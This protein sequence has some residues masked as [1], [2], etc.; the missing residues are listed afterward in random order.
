MPALFDASTDTSTGGLSCD[1]NVDNGVPC[2]CTF[3]YSMVVSSIEIVVFMVAVAAFLLTRLK[4]KIKIDF[5]SIALCTLLSLAFLMHYSFVLY[6][7]VGPMGCRKIKEITS[8]IC[9]AP[10]A[11]FFLIFIWAIFKLLVIWRV[12]ISQTNH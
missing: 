5:R 12:M 4:K 6:V 1:P 9:F 7:F 8:Y 10:Q 2:V 3:E 11:I